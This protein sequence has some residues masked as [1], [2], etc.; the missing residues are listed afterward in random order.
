MLPDIN[1]FDV[2][3]IALARAYPVDAT[4]KATSLTVSLGSKWWATALLAQTIQ[5]A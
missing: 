1:G 2:R 5:S 4:A 3:E